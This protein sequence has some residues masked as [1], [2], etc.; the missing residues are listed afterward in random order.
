MDLVWIPEI[1]VEIRDMD[2]KEA[3]W[4]AY[5]SVPMRFEYQTRLC[6]LALYFGEIFPLS[7]P[8]A[9]KDYSVLDGGPETWPKRFCLDG[10]RFWIAFYHG[11][12]VGAAAVAPAT[13][14]VDLLEHREDLAVLWDLRVHPNFAHRGI[15]RRLL[16]LAEKWAVSEGFNEMK[17]ETQDVN[18]LA[19][20]FYSACG[21]RLAGVL[22]G[23]YDGLDDACLYFRKVLTSSNGDI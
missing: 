19:C 21:Y 14:G 6:L 7:V 15:G 18:E 11:Q 9:V 8:L 5:R 13:S 17:I 3:D 23:Q 4:Q 20:R 1:D 2:A 10:W 16:H 12:P 22:V